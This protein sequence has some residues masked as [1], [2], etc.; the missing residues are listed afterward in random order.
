MRHTVGKLSMRATTLLQTSSWSKVHTQ[1]YRSLKSQESQV[2]EF[3]NSHLG[4]LGQNAICM[5]ASWRGTKYTIRGK[6]VASPKFKPWW[7]LWVQVC[8]WLFLAPKVLK[9]CINQL[10]VWFVQVCVSNW[11][12]SL[13]LVSISELHHAPLPPKCCEPK[14]VPQFFTLPLFPP[15]THIWVYK[16]GWEC[17]IFPPK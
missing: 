5:W 14:N 16:G 11:C 9:L 12:L 7:V 10:V 4:V 13:F 1:S 6:V 8:P 3:R 15:Y 2:W 17:I